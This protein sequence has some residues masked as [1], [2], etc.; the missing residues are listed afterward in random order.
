ML[1]NECIGYLGIVP[2]G[3]YIDCTIGGAG[4]ASEIAKRLDTRGRL[5]GIDRDAAAVEAAWQK[6]ERQSQIVRFDIVQSN[7]LYIEKISREVGIEKANG[8]LMDLGASSHQ[9]DEADRGFSY[10]SNA[11]LDMRMDRGAELT[12]ETVVNKY[13]ERDLVAII[14]KYGEERWAARIGKFIVERRELGKIRTTGELVEII[15][16]AVPKQ[17]RRDGPH[18]AKRTFQAIRIEV[19]DELTVLK[20]SIDACANMLE[21]NGRLCVISFHSLED[22]IV[23]TA[24]KEL[25][26]TC[27]CPRGA[28]VCIC[29]TVPKLRV[30]SK[31]PILPGQEEIKENPRARSAKLRV[32]ERLPTGS[33]A[34]K[35]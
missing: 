27:V 10:N 2:D 6:L 9:L 34:V 30:V 17:V 26:A 19:N 18:P 28:P 20:K 1:L 11:A 24:F 21:A 14:A 25:S 4:H 12:A 35:K 29:G 8:I 13:A 23:K 31:K 33:Q 16:A 7:Y 22:R 3:V 15:K 32:A 5:L